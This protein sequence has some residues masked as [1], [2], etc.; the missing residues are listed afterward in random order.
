MNNTSQLTIKQYIE[1][2]NVKA[3]VEELLKDR[4][5]QFMITLSSMVNN[6]AKLQ[7]CEPGSLFTAAL[8]IVAMDLP[9]NNNL[10]F[11]W[12]IPYNDRKSGKVFAQAQLGYKAFVQLAMRSGQFKTLNVTDVRQGEFKGIDRLSGEMSLKWEENE[13]KRTKLLVIGFVA[14]MR[15]LNGFEKSFYMTATEA[16]AHGQKYSANFKKYNSGM[17]A[18]E[19]DAMAKKTVLKLMLSKYAPMSANMAKAVEVDQAVLIDEKTKYIDNQ[20]ESAADISEDKEKNRVLKYIKNCKSLKSLMMCKSSCVTDELAEAYTEKESK[21]KVKDQTPAP[22]VGVD[23]AQGESKTVETVVE[24]KEEEQS[25]DEDE[26]CEEC[27]STDLKEIWENN[28]FPEGEGPTKNE[29]TGMVCNNCG[30][31]Q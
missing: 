8:T 2:P 14:Y 21:L 30:H 6:D 10:G 16:R 17:W 19:F 13:E 18:D 22:T 15:L 26:K 5:S 3:R 1:Q 11:A 31:K 24:P 29:I 12:I 25:T 27:G 7:Q 9:V 23:T 20:K 4:A 28:G